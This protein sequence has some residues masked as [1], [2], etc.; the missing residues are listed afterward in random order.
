M[1]KEI[2]IKLLKVF[3]V[4]FLV[5]FID[6]FF[7]IWIKTNLMI[8]ESIRVL[9]W[10]YILSIENNGMAFGMELFD[11]MF[12]TFFRII[13]VVAIGYYV[14]YTIKKGFNFGFTVAIALIFAGALGNIID[15]V[16]YGVLFNSSEG[17]VAVFLPEVGGYAP[18]FQGRVVDML[19]FPLID[20]T[21][22]SWMPSVGG[23]RFTFFDP[24]FNIADS[25]ICFGVFYILLFQRKYILNSDKKERL[26]KEEDI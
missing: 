17:Q 6:Q 13:A 23:T 22:P 4:V 20:T 19:Y 15:C 18:L 3:L 12:L 11:K 10:F 24:V 5:L 16:F 21:W 26:N 9:D 2:K 14:Y 8:G 1:T 25:V 7:K